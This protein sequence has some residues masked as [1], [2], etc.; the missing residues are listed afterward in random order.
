MPEIMATDRERQL[1]NKLGVERL[2]P[3]VQR[4]LE[5][6]RASILDWAIRTLGYA[7]IDPEIH[8]LYRVEGTAQ[9]SGRISAWRAILK[10]FIRPTVGPPALD[11]PEHFL[12]WEREPLAYASGLLDELPGGLRAAACY[13]V[14]RP[15]PTLAFVWLEDVIDDYPEGWPIERYALAARHL[16]QF[17]GAYLVDRPLP[18]AP[19]FADARSV[20]VQNSASNTDFGPQVV[21]FLGSDAPLGAVAV[22]RAAGRRSAVAALA[23]CLAHQD[24]LVDRLATLPQTFCHGDPIGPNL[25]A[26]RSRQGDDE[27]VA[28]DWGLTGRAPIGGELASLVGGS[29]GFF[30]VGATAADELE[31]AAFAAYL[32]GLAD[33]GARIDGRVVRFG[34]L[35]TLMLRWGAGAGFWLRAALD[36]TEATWVEAFFGRPV[37]SVRDHYRE[38][39]PWLGRLARET[40]PLATSRKT[41]R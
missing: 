40:R 6:P 5:D 35:A 18:V 1:L 11:A 14:E 13:G 32:D 22:G 25:F 30:R 9:S 7:N 17:N 3:I 34:Y 15:G 27:T 31:R 4:A 41:T 10:V 39:V 38:L 28:I 23:D 37:S 12:Y 2:T 20:Q 24:I 21:E 36:P 29:L 19:W 8:S 26:R 16:G 33:A